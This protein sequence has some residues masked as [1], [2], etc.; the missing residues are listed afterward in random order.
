MRPRG[1]RHRCPP[2][3]NVCRQ[4]QSNRGRHFK[5]KRAA[6]PHRRLEPHQALRRGAAVE[7]VTFTLEPGT[8]TGFVGANGA[9]KSTTLRMLLGLTRPTAGTATIDGKQYAAL[10]DPT[11]P[12]VPSPTRLSSTPDDPGATHFASSPARHAFP[13]AGWT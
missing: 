4:P 9:G 8:L 2:V 12:W 6:C 13:T 1:R 11:R 5:R 3:P 7:D 10:T